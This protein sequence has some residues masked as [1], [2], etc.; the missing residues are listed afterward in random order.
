MGQNPKRS[1]AW[2]DD[3]SLEEQGPTDLGMAGLP[4]S[5]R[6]YE[7]KAAAFLVAA[8]GLLETWTSGALLTGLSSLN[9][10][11]Q[12]VWLLFVVLILCV[13][14]GHIWFRRR[15][16]FGFHLCALIAITALIGHTL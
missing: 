9:H 15:P 4:E 7:W 2:H 8:L 6:H 11:A 1:Y 10:I 5:W 13:G 14:L 3:D 12:S 16:S